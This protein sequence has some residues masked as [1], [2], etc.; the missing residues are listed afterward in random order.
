VSNYRELIDLT[1]DIL[2]A[3]TRNYRRL[4]I[5]FGTI[6]LITLCTIVIT[7]SP[8]PATG[9]LFLLPA[10]G[11]FLFFDNRS[12]NVWRARI[13]DAW[14]TKEVDL[15]A[16]R[17]ALK[18]NKAFPPQTLKGMIETL[19]Q[20]DDL[21]T[22]QSVSVATRNALAVLVFARDDDLE[23][24]LL[25]QAGSHCLITFTLASAVVLEHWLLLSVIILV[26]GIRMLC[27]WR[28]SRNLSTAMQKM[29]RYRET[30]GFA[31]DIYE[32]VAST[33]ACDN[34]APRV[35]KRLTNFTDSE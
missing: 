35:K 3:R 21:A 7:M 28:D 9:L 33:V 18:T 11:L 20:L 24:K 34:S 16:L 27:R 29:V 1:S 12:L 4:V 17:E 32:S 5:S 30:R 25:C 10:Y 31:P 14:R 26:P 23:N 13:L 6:G 19:P 2:A 15:S 22:E 8:R